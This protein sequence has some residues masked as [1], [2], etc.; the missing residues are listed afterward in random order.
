MEDLEL[1]AQIAAIQHP[2]HRAWLNA[3]L[4]DQARN[5]TAACR[6]AGY[7]STDV[8]LHARANRLK[9]RYSQLIA[10]YDVCQQQAGIIGPREAQ[11]LLAT[12][13]RDPET[14]ARDRLKAIELVLR[15][16]GMLTDQVKV[17]GNLNVRSAIMNAISGGNASVTTLPIEATVLELPA[18]EPQDTDPEAGQSS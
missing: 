9:R 14:Q 12:I 10:A 16:H 1:E 4:A 17:E 2:R 3:Y 8:S 7:T 13:A 18:G 11:T 6:V 15:I 5:A